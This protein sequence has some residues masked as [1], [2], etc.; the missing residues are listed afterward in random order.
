M[1]THVCLSFPQQVRTCLT[2]GLAMVINTASIKQ[3]W[4]TFSLGMSSR[5]FGMTSQVSLHTPFPPSPP[6]LKKQTNKQTNKREHTGSFPPPFFS[7][8]VAK[9]EANLTRITSFGRLP[10]PKFLFPF[11]SL[12]DFRSFYSLSVVEITPA[13]KMSTFTVELLV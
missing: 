1:F 2:A 10:T 6:S 12:P 3:H 5:N 11:I 4:Q 9:K 8:L 7:E 13:G